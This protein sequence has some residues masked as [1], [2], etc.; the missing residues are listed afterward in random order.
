MKKNF[1]N[2]KVLILGMGSTGISICNFLKNKKIDIYCWDD[3]KCKLENI[4]KSFSIYSNEKLSL[5]ECIYVSPGISKNH[6]IVKSALE[7]KINI[8][9]DI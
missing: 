7:N 8:S 3:N 5:F 9:S 2:K 1:N 4:E 6:K